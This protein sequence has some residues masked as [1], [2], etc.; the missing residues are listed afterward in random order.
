MKR[1]LLCA[2]ACAFLFTII[3]VFLTFASA[4]DITT[5][6]VDILGPPFPV[7]GV[8]VSDSVYFG[9]ISVGDQ[10]DDVKIDINNTGNIGI[11]V[12]PRLVAGSDPVFNYT[13]FKRVTN[14]PYYKIGQ[15]NHNISAPTSGSVRSSFMY[16]KLDLREYEGSFSQGSVN[17][18]TSDV[19]FFIAAQ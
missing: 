2:V 11:S 19:K 18:L 14:E 15:Y 4:G 17:R 5:F 1:L 7:L 9:N 12:A 16:A 3:S 6:K 13:Y 8:E 10:S